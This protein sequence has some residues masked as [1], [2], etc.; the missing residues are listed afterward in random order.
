ME[1]LSYST[2]TYPIKSIEE[3]SCVLFHTPLENE[4]IA[5][6]APTLF[7][8]EKVALASGF[9]G[10]SVNF[11]AT[12]VVTLVVLVTLIYVKRDIYIP[13]GTKYLSRKEKSH[14]LND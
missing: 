8:T 2:P 4:A 10:F 12:L 9:L 14:L 13:K 1:A 11:I 6:G 5:I 3:P 7:A